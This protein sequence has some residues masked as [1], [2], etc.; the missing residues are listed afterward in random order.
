DGLLDE[1]KHRDAP[2]AVYATVHPHERGTPPG[3]ALLQRL[4]KISGDVE[5]ADAAA[6]GDLA[7]IH[8]PLARLPV[9]RVRLRLFGDVAGEVVPGRMI[10]RV[11]TDVQLPRTFG[12]HRRLRTLRG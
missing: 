8:Q 4:E 6:I 10:L 9:A 3:P 1:R 11:R 7:E 12:I 5:V 2:V